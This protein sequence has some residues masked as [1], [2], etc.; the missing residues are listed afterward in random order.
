MVQ[1]SEIQKEGFC[2]Y[3]PFVIF[4][5]GVSVIQTFFPGRYGKNRKIF[6]IHDALCLLGFFS[7]HMNYH[8][9]F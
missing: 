5:G 8:T 2:K 3:C 7:E 6:H 9:G 4:V 1:G